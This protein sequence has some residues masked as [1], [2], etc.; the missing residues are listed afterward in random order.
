MPFTGLGLIGAVLLGSRRKNRKAAM[1]FLAMALMLAL[2]SCGGGS[3]TPVTTP[4]TPAGT[5]TITTTAASPNVTH[6]T[7][8][9]L[10]V[11]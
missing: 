3:H 7:T 1:I 8:F 9:T 5:Y 11:N 4:G 6:S 2:A 10:V